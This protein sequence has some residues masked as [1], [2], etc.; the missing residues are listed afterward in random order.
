VLAIL[1]R[2]SRRGATTF[3]RAS[4]SVDPGQRVALRLTLRRSARFTLMRRGRLAARLVVARG[5]ASSDR[6]LVTLLAPR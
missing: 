2:P 4:F 5:G 1:Q 6:R 3:A